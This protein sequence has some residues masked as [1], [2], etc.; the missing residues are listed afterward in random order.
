MRLIQEVVRDAIS[1]YSPKRAQKPLSDDDLANFENLFREHMTIYQSHWRDDPEFD[2]SN[3]Q[4]TIPQLPCPT[5]D[6][7]LLMR[8]ARYPVE[9]KF[10]LPRFE[11]L[12]RKADAHERLDSW[13]QTAL[14]E[15]LSPYQSIGLQVNGCGG[16]QWQLLIRDGR[17]IGAR[18]GLG[19]ESSARFYLNIDTFGSLVAGHRSIAETIRSGRLL[20]EGMNGG[21]DAY[22]NLLEQVLTTG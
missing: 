6:Y 21:N 8:V 20:I 22:E 15:P 14:P 3:T 11:K 16:G 9:R 4:R 13:I 7:D 5:V 1:R 17:V 18:A 12:D 19:P 2:I 10:S